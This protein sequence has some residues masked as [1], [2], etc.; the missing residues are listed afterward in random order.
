MSSM[1]YTVPPAVAIL[2]LLWL[3]LRK[4]SSSPEKIR[5]RLADLQAGINAPTHFQF[6]PQIRQALSEADDKYLAEAA[7]ASVAR[8][9]R[10]VRRR[11]AR[12]FLRGLRED[13]SNLEH[14]G[15]MIAAMSPEISRRQEAERFALGLKFQFI[16]AL[17]WLRLLTG[18]LP[19][20]H[21][22]NL[23]GLVGRLAASMER[24]MSEINA[25]SA[26]QIPGSV[27]V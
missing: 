19:V 1:F 24:A 17:V 8:Q 13:Y 26:G 2:V 22:Q 14:L 7:P 12:D 27:N 15:R 16:C 4:R 5:G 9:A 25:L 20:V 23:T 3:L 11:V 18:N 6:F 10:R 21:L